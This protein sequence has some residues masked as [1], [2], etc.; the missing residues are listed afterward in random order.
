MNR[1]HLGG[2]L[3]LMLAGLLLAACGSGSSGSGAAVSPSLRG[4]V[5]GGQSPVSGS[6]VTLYAAGTGPAAASSLGTATTDANGNFL[7]GGFTCPSATT[8]VYVV[9][10]GGNP[11][12]G[13]SV[14]NSALD[15][16]AAL[17]SCGSLPASITINEVTTVA[18]AYALNGFIGGSGC[19]NCG[20]GVPSD[21]D[22][23]HGNDPGLSNAMGNAARLAS[24]ASGSA[25]P[26][27]PSASACAAGAPPVN[28]GAEQ[29]INALANILAACVN[30]SSGAS[31][32]CVELFDCATPGASFSGGACT[33][34]GGSI[35]ATDTLQALLEIARN[36]GTVPVAGVYDVAT[37][38]PVFSPALNAAPSDWTLALNITGGGLDEIGFVN[39][40]SKNIAIDASGNAWVVNYFNNSLSEFSPDGTAL[41]A[42]GYTGGGL[43]NPDAIAIDL[44]GKVW[45][46]NDGVSSLS[47]FNSAGTALSGSGGYTGGGLNIPNGI[48]IDASGNVWVANVNSSLSEFNS[49]GTALSGSGGYTGGGLNGPEDVAIDA[50]GNVWVTNSNPSLSKFNSAGTALSGSGGYTGGGLNGPEGIAID[51]SG[52]VWVTNNGSGSL[53]EFNSAGTALS[54]SSGYAGGGLNGPE[55]IAIDASGNVWIAN[56]PSGSLSEFNSAGTA[57]SGSSGYTGGGLNGAYGIATDPSGDVWITNDNNTLTELIGAAAPTRT[58]LVSAISNGFTP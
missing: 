10:R 2:A 13:G 45:V 1:K 44:S 29:R 26:P 36:A 22:N 7:L 48:A 21:V 16:M 20:S 57:L 6:T 40:F 3:A 27:L 37:R 41:S 15:E 33:V 18:A 34:P 52:N 23:V 17:G 31:S 28:C 46:A 49:A 4:I 8:S 55:G 38:N 14:N 58:P 24:V 25:S 19:V 32:E 51:A 56:Y 43:N 50:G 35:L 30:T 9:A 39:S 11:G 5:H 42:N 47:E 53:S 12:L 54:G